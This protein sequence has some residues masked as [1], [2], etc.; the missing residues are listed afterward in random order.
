MTSPANKKADRIFVQNGRRVYRRRFSSTESR[1]GMLILAG[2]AAVVIWIAWKGAHPDPSLFML[3]TDLSQSGTLA[4]ADRGPLPA[5]LAA[6]GWRESPPTQ[7]DAD[8]LYEKINGR[9]GYYKSH[10][11]EQLYCLTIVSDASAQSTID[12]ELYD[13]GTAANALG[14]Y[15]GE[16]SPDTKADASDAGLM[17]ID[18]NA[19]YLTRGKYYLRAIGSEESPAMKEHLNHIAQRFTADVPGEAFPWGYRL[20][21][22]EMGMEPGQISFAAEGAFSFGFATNVY[23]ARLDDGAD[24]FVTPS[25]SESEASDL[26]ERFHEGFLQHSTEEG[27][28]LKDRYLDT[29]AGVRGAGSWVVGVY[30]APDAKS[31]INALQELTE[32]VREWRQLQENSEPA[33]SDA[34]EEEYDGDEY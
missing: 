18:R 31:A 9:E 21:I 10:G 7:F 25:T 27:T 11:F 34:V 32:V 13:L 12:I 14:A 6:I 1:A 22:G 30:R 26:A 17:H 20:F 8:N 5:Q 19:L 33:G 2:L 3:E 29:Y 4:P 23:M 24:L 16:K 28:L 15:S